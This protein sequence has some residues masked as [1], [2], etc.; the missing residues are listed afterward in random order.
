MFVAQLWASL[1]PMN[2]S[3]PGSSVEFPRQEYWSGLP[4]PSPG[5]LPDPEMEPESPVAPAL[6]GGFFTSEPPGKPSWVSNGPQRWGEEEP[7]AL[8]Q[9]VHQEVPGCAHQSHHPPTKGVCGLTLQTRTPRPR[10]FE[11]FGPRLRSCYVT[12]GSLDL[13]FIIL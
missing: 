13:G 10:K 11:Q 7:P 9:A 3:P 4:F 6:A 1:G 12:E 8:L 2:C 5:D